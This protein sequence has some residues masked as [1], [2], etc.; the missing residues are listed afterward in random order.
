MEGGKHTRTT[1]RQTQQGHTPEDCFFTRQTRVHE[2][3]AAMLRKSQ[4]PNP[5]ILQGQ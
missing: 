3:M 2:V 1:E 5:K 4:E